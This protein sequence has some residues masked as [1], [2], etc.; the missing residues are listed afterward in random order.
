MAPHPWGHKSRLPGGSE[1]RKASPCTSG[2]P[3]FD[4]GLGREGNDKPIPLPLPGKIP[5]GWGAWYATVLHVR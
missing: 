1:G 4:S 2:S 3:R 5:H